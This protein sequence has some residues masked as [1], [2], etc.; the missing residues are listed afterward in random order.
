LLGGVLGTWLGLRE[1]IGI[2]GV[3]GLLLGLTLLKVSPLTRMREL[4][5]TP[6]IIATQPEM[7]AE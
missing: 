1:T 5:A 3:C 2:C 7:S 6:P 4:P